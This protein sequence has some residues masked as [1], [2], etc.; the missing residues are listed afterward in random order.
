MVNSSPAMDCPQDVD[1]P[2]IKPKGVRFHSRNSIEQVQRISRV[3]Q[4]YTPDEIFAVWGDTEEF[5]LRKQELRDTVQRIKQG[6]RD[7]DNINTTTLGLTQM[8]GAGRQE[9]KMNRV[10]AVDTVMQEQ[11]YQFMYE[12]NNPDQIADV[13]HDTTTASRRKARQ[14]AKRIEEEVQT[15]EAGMQLRGKDH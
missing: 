5:Y 7:S 8:Y 13:Y 6:R 11:Q 10:R 1:M 14:E 4:C 3:S 2:P 15:F 12:E 9:K